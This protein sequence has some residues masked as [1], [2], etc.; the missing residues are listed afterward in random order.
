MLPAQNLGGSGA[1]LL[2]CCRVTQHLCTQLQHHARCLHVQQASSVATVKPSVAPVEA[3]CSTG[4][5]RPAATVTA[6]QSSSN[7]LMGAIEH[8]LAEQKLAGPSH[9]ATTVRTGLFRVP[10][11]SPLNG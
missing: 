5:P 1:V 2:A 9:T 11:R 4:E 7:P 3:P 6:A 10:R 8:L